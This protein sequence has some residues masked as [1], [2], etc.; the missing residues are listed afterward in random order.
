MAKKKKTETKVEYYEY[1]RAI[2]GYEP[3][4]DGDD[5]VGTVTFHYKLKGAK[6]A[7]HDDHDED[8]KDFTDEEIKHLARSL[9][10]VEKDDPVEV[11][12]EYD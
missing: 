8:V 4:D 12:V 7:G 6:V 3:T 10:S 1:I 5:T 9:L 2:R 11:E